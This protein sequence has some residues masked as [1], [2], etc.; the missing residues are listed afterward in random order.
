MKIVSYKS[1]E[2]F[3]VQ[4]SKIPAFSLAKIIKLC[5][6]GIVLVFITFIPLRYEVECYQLGWMNF[7]NPNECSP[8]AVTAWIHTQLISSFQ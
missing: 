2:K 6:F 3:A 5:N 1:H 8:S 4:K 7:T